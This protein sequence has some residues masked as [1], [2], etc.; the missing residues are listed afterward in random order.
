MHH[1]AAGH[2]GKRKKPVLPDCKH[3]PELEQRRCHN[4]PEY[5]VTHRSRGSPA[6]KMAAQRA[7]RIHFAAKKPAGPDASI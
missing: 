1:H 3:N 2:T 7:Q 5:G 4:Q 6:G